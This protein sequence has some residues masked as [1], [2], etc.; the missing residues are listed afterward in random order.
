M[1]ERS[2]PST[3]KNLA[4]TS[5]YIFLKRVF[6]LGHGTFVAG[7]RIEPLKPIFLDVNIDFYFGASTRRYT[8][9]PK[10][11]SANEINLNEMNEEQDLLNLPEKEHE[12][13]VSIRQVDASYK[14]ILQGQILWEGAT[15]T[16][17]QRGVTGVQLQGCR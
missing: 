16:F 7:V 9:R 10:L 17:L 8:L 5:P 12:L 1:W 14:E 11:S 6:I 15:A 13:D 4:M 3:L 2:A